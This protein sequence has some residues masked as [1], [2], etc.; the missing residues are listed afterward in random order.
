MKEEIRV[1]WFGHGGSRYLAEEI[2]SE[3]F[4]SE[5]KDKKF[6]CLS[7]WDTNKDR[8]DI[9]YIKWDKETWL[10]EIRRADIV[11]L[12]VEKDKPA[13][14]DN[15][16]VIAVTLGKKVICSPTDAY[17][18]FF[19]RYQH[20]PV[21]YAKDASDFR[22]MIKSHRILK[23]PSSDILANIFSDYSLPV[24][25][26]NYTNTLGK[27]KE[28]R[29]TA[30][31]SAVLRP[32]AHPA[33]LVPN[34]LSIIIPVKYYRGREHI[35]NAAIISI[36]NAAGNVFGSNHE[37]CIVR[38]FEQ[39]IEDPYFSDK[40]FFVHV[41]EKT[42]F[43]EAIN[44]GLENTNGE[45]LLIANDDVYAGYKSIEV[46]YDAM[47]KFPEMAQVNPFS[48]CDKGWL[49]DTPI[50]IDG[51]EYGPDVSEDEFKDKTGLLYIASKSH[52]ESRKDAIECLNI[53]FCPLYFTLINRIIFEG[54]GGRLNESMK[55][56]YSD[57]ELSERFQMLGYKTTMCRNAFVFHYGAKSRKLD[58]K[59]DKGQYQKIDIEDNMNY[60]EIM[61][62]R[63]EKKKVI[64]YSGPS[65]ERWGPDSL[66]KGIGGSESCQIYLAEALADLGYDV[67]SICDFNS[68]NGSLKEYIPKKGRLVWDHMDN[69]DK[70]V[71]KEHDIFISV[72]QPILPFEPKA[73]KKILWS[74]DIWYGDHVR[75]Y[76]QNFNVHVLLSPWHKS[77][78][79]ND[80]GLKCLENKIYIIPDGV[81]DV[82]MPDYI[83]SRKPKNS[84][85][86]KLIYSSSPDRGL[87][88]LLSMYE[89]LHK[90]LS[91]TKCKLQLHIYYGFYNL[92]EYSKDRDKER[93]D[94]GKK[95]IERIESLKNIGVVNHDRVGKAELMQGFMDADMWVYP[96]Y[97]YETF[98][99]TALEAMMTGCLPIYMN[100][101]ALDTTIPKYNPHI[102]GNINAP[103]NYDK[104]KDLFFENVELYMQDRNLYVRTLLSNKNYAKSFVWNNI[105]MRWD[106]LFMQLLKGK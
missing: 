89:D 15:R 105:S 26:A 55:M 98:C 20:I 49:H 87:D 58:E 32:Y 59:K 82:I 67:V 41:P 74:H 51:K 70:Y 63:D 76:L 22:L 73:K 37:I 23:S 17:N 31:Q 104:F 11:V 3:R 42:T 44:I 12:P 69:F 102:D 77:Y 75:P 93:Y 10:D 57:K 81:I 83:K 106:D 7:E 79:V 52:W 34:E 2:F 78:W 64:I 38:T 97:F 16:L 9:T 29:Q 1:L 71:N 80:L 39:G 54:I 24:L 48:N 103:G 25:M 47:I 85:V 91:K 62:Y 95:L 65:W 36:H 94:W 53:P 68:L 33:V 4:I 60:A 30:I 90:N 21:L 100:L 50:A 92:L 40:S 19:D 13:K 14:S 99:I 66:L 6:I 45:Y 28:M 88:V 46:M 35:V 96:T 5:N 86:L 8:S 72:R 18:K 101:A 56:V 43:T 27:L 61:E 84:N